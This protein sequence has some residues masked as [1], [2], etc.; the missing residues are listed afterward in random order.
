MRRLILAFVALCCLSCRPTAT[1]T[2]IPI[3]VTSTPTVTT[4]PRPTWTPTDTGTATR[5]D[6]PTATWTPYPRATAIDTALSGWRHL[7]QGVIDGPVIVEIPNIPPHFPGGS[8]GYTMVQIYAEN[9]DSKPVRVF[10]AGLGL[11]VA[12]GMAVGNLTGTALVD[13]GLL[14]L[15]SNGAI[16]LDLWRYGDDTAGAGTPYPTIATNPATR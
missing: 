8:W 1:P 7:F 5:T 6:T 13:Q 12:E 2:P 14:W 4:T 9:R 11:E 16:W 15:D 10:V 3:V